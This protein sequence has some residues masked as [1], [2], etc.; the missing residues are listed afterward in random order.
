MQL[1]I[2]SQG[3][4]INPRKKYLFAIEIKSESEREGFGMAP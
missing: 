1:T 2:N 3:K 4:P